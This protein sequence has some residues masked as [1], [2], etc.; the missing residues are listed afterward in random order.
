MIEAIQKQIQD[1]VRRLL[2]DKRVDL[3]I[4]FEKGTLPLRSAPIFIHDSADTNRLIWN[5]FCENNLANYLTKINNQRV[6]IIAKGCDVRSIIALTIEKQIDRDQIIIIGIPCQGMIDWRK[7]ER[8]ANGEL[9]ETIEENNQIIIRGEIF[10]QNL[11]RDA[12]LYMSCQTCQY[13]NPVIYDIL[14]GEKVKEISKSKE[15]TDIAG[16]ETKAP[17]ERWAY[18]CEQTSKCIRCYA[19]REACPMCYCEECFVDCT[20]PKWIEKGLNPSDVQIWQIIRALH[21]AGRCCGCGACERACP[22]EVKLCYLTQKI[23]KDIREL[24]GFETGISFE[25]PPPLATFNLND[26]QDFIYG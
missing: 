8:E 2:T 23:S 22:M 21:L 4:G 24:F 25:Q 9:L 7:V 18:F 26:N 14:I 5:S 20:T 19:C 3:V 15:Y 1:E 6:A 11:K 16:L 12:F 13:R 17:D 10:E